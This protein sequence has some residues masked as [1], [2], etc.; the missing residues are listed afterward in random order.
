MSHAKVSQCPR[1][2]ID[3][4]SGEIHAWNLCMDCRRANDRGVTTR[5]Q[6]SASA[7]ASIVA[8][9][10]AMAP[11]LATQLTMERLAF[12]RAVLAARIEGLEMA[13]KIAGEHGNSVLTVRITAAIHDKIKELR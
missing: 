5:D 8:Y 2:G 12:A 13:K 9:L 4:P 7:S 11:E 10:Q 6:Q 3:A 1:C